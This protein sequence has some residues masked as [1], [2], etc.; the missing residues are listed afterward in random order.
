MGRDLFTAS[1]ASTARK[2]EWVR[3]GVIQGGPVQQAVPDHAPQQAGM[4]RKA[5]QASTRGLKDRSVWGEGGG[6][7]HLHHNQLITSQQT[8]SEA[9]KAIFIQGFISIDVL[10]HAWLFQNIL[11]IPRMIKKPGNFGKSRACLENAGLFLQTTK[12]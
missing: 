11:G 2:E 12:T 8:T 9:A 1:R 3:R 5:W 4:A 10:K 7:F 6:G